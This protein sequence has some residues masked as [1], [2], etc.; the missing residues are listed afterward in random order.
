MV[1]T[2]SQPSLLPFSD[3]KIFPE[4]SLWVDFGKSLAPKLPIKNRPSTVLRVIQGVGSHLFVSW[5]P[6]HSKIYLIRIP[7]VNQLNTV[8]I[9]FWVLD[10]FYVHCGSSMQR[11]Y[12]H[13]RRHLSLTF[14]TSVY[15]TI[16]KKIRYYRSTIASVLSLIFSRKEAINN[17]L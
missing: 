17:N 10:F 5:G 14:P 9:I 16:C 12:S 8:A 1:M 15:H 11:L 2:I 13:G 3:I 7:V 4:S 6:S